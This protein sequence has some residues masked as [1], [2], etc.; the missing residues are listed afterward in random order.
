[1][2]GIGLR[3][4]F[5]VI[6]F[7]ILSLTAISISSVHYH[8]FKG[9][10]HR[11]IEL[12][13]QQNASILAN[14]DLNL[15]K[16]EF[17]DLGQEFADELIGDDKINVIV[18][19]YN[20]EGKVLYRNDNAYVFDMPES[21][22]PN[23][24]EWEDIEK[25]DYFIKYMTIFDQDQQ[26]IIKVGMILNQSLLRWRDLNQ[27]ILVF[28]L[29]LFLMILVISFLLTFLLFRPVKVL[30]DQ[31][32]QMAEQVENG[33]FVDLQYWLGLL[34]GASRRP[35]EFQKLISSLQKLANKISENQGMTQKWSALMA[36]ELKTPMTILRMSIDQLTAEINAPKDKID[37]VEQE[38][39][40][41]EH[42]IMDFLEWAS[43]ENDTNSPELHAI[44]LGKRARELT[45]LFQATY[46]LAN[47]QFSE[48][49]EEFR[50]LCNPLHFDQLI[51]NLLT[52][53]YKFAR[54]T[55]SIQVKK[56]SIT[57]SDDGPGISEAVLENFG[58]PFNK[59]SSKEKAGHGLGLAWVSTII[60]KYGW[61]MDLDNSRGA[62]F[63]I[64]FPVND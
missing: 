55:I 15:S 63:T 47:V 20:Q 41:L 58:R 16:K 4:R 46:P 3:L 38:L 40:K 32:N 39:K 35:D 5:F 26:R 1:M 7:C 31:V 21:I 24:Q 17:S 57:I 56:N 10:R 9:E 59:S 13:L 22:S 62:S 14:A 45:G 34:K 44:N 33:K 30:A 11:L 53:A 48:C 51:N 19:I 49:N 54:S 36:H 29:I 28:G 61:K 37:Q 8:F 12:N 18:G 23:F 52:N 42:I 6:I 2:W 43:M 50:V 64:H 60:R 25:K 27:R